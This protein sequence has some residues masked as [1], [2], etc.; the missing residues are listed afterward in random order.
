[1]AGET[2]KELLSIALKRKDELELESKALDSLIETYK[3]LAEFEDKRSPEQMNLWSAHHS[4]RTRSSYLADLLA[5]VRRL[6]IAA[7]H[8][9]NRGELVKKLEAGGQ[10]IDGKNKAKVL[11]TNIW[12]SG[13][14][15]HVDGYGYWPS[16]TPIPNEFT[17]N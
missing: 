3:K 5:E 7:G 2:A 15:V 8:P 14:F 17:A 10:T 13:Q 12:R 1:M 16:D 11:G 6:I 9:L 4:K